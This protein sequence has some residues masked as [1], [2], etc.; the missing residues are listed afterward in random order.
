MYPNSACRSHLVVS[1]VQLGYKPGWEQQ[2]L[3]QSA[4]SEIRRGIHMLRNDLLPYPVFATAQA[5][6]GGAT[7]PVGLALMV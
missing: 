2:L 5:G 6:K 1:T 4:Q 3:A 7:H